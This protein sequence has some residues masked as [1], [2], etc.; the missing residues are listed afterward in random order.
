MKDNDRVLARTGARELD[1]QEVEQVL[2]GLR[3][4]T[5][6]SH[7]ATTRDGDVFLGEC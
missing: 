2:G 1:E 4:Q 6:C 7:S 5:K 3:T